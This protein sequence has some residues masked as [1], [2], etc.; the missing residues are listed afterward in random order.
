MENYHKAWGCRRM[1]LPV[2]YEVLWSSSESWGR[3]EKRSITFSS[4]D[5]CLN[6]RA[7]DKRD[8]DWRLIWLLHL[9][10][11]GQEKGSSIRSLAEVVEDWLLYPFLF[12]PEENHGEGDVWGAWATND[13]LAS[14]V[15]HSAMT[16]RHLQL[17]A[18]RRPINEPASQNP[19]FILRGRTFIDRGRCLYIGK[20]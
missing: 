17:L 14:T 5:G 6:D 15:S 3:I 20:S 4:L 8:L 12:F 1:R 10:K 11:T 7:N 18:W 13:A 9:T 19:D 16:F 2:K